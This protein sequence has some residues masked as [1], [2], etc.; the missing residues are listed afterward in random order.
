VH[1][2]INHTSSLGHRQSLEKHTQR[3]G[4][5]FQNITGWRK[6]TDKEFWRLH[7]AEQDSQRRHGTTQAASN[8]YQTL[9]GRQGRPPFKR[10]NCPPG[11][12]LL[13]LHKH[14]SMK[15]N[16][17]PCSTYAQYG[18]SLFARCCATQVAQPVSFHSQRMRLRQCKCPKQGVTCRANGG[19]FL[20]FNASGAAV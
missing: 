15:Q 13:Q 20:R 17:A 18:M 1:N 2:I 4:H 7:H 10:S 9:F 12:G 5:G 8:N 19:P 16:L 3:F 6:T 11:R 14:A